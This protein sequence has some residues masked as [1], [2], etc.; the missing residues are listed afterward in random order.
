MADK[1]LQKVAGSP[2][3][4]VDLEQHISKIISQN[5]AIVETLDP[6]WSKKFMSSRNNNSQSN[7]SCSS[8]SISTAHNRH[9][10]TSSLPPSFRPQLYHH[11]LER[12]QQHQQQHQQQQ[13]QHQQ[14]VAVSSPPVPAVSPSAMSRG[15]SPL[16]AV[17]YTRRRYSDV[18]FLNR[19]HGASRLQSALL[20]QPLTSSTAATFTTSTSQAAVSASAVAVS[21]VVSQPS[22][23]IQQQPYHHQQQQQQNN[24]GGHESVIKNGRQ[25]VENMQY[26]SEGPS[27]VNL[28]TSK[29][30]LVK[31]CAPP[32]SVGKPQAC[33][34]GDLHPE[35]PERSVIKDLLL[36]AR[37]KECAA[38][39]GTGK[40][41]SPLPA[42]P[43]QYLAM[44][45]PGNVAGSPVA[46][47][48]GAG[49]AASSRSPLGT[50][51]PPSPPINQE[52]LSMLY[53]VCTI[54]KIAFRNKEN[55]E[56]HQLHYCKGVLASRS[57]LPSQAFSGHLEQRPANL[58]L[59]PH[60]RD[61]PQRVYGAQVPLAVPVNSSFQRKVS[62]MESVLHRRLTEGPPSVSPPAPVAEGQPPAGA[63]GQMGAPIS[64]GTILKKTLESPKKRKFSE[65]VFPSNRFNHTPLFTDEHTAMPSRKISV[66]Q[67][68][69]HSKLNYKYS[70]GSL[71]MSTITTHVAKPVPVFANIA[72]PSRAVSEHE[73]MS[74][75][76][77]ATSAA[78][79]V[80]KEPVKSSPAGQEVKLDILPDYMPHLSLPKTKITL[81]GPLMFPVLKRILAEG[82]D[83]IEFQAKAVCNA[84]EF[85]T[86]KV[87]LLQVATMLTEDTDEPK[88]RE[89]DALQ[90]AVK[91]SS[92]TG[93][94]DKGQ[95][96]SAALTV[97]TTE[98]SIREIPD[99]P[100]RR[101]STLQFQ[102][103]RKMSAFALIGS[104]LV[105]PDTP[106]PKKPS[107][108]HLVTGQSYSFIGL[109]VST[110]TT[111]CCIYRPQPMFVTQETQPKLSMYSNWQTIA[112]QDDLL[113][114]LTPSELLKAYDSDVVTK[115]SM[116]RRPVIYVLSESNN[117]GKGRKLRK[118]NLVTTHS[119]YWISRQQEKAIRERKASFVAR[120]ISSCEFDYDENNMRKISED[121][122]S[123]TSLDSDCDPSHPK[124]V[125]I[126]EGG[127]KSN[128]DYTY[129]RGRGRGKYVCEECGIRCKKPSM[130][131]KHIRTHT[132]LRP[133]S[134]RHCA[135]AFKT[136]GNLTKHMKSKAHHKKCVELGIVP[137]PT[138]IDESQIDSDALAKQEALE[139][140]C[141]GGNLMSDDDDNDEDEEEDEDCSDDEGVPIPL[142][143]ATCYPASGAEKLA[144]ATSSCSSL[145]G[146]HENKLRD[147]TN[148]LNSNGDKLDIGD[149]RSQPR[150]STLQ[151]ENEQ[152]QPRQSVNSM[153]C[154]NSNSSSCSSASQND[155]QEVAQSLLCL[156]GSWSESNN[157]KSETESSKPD[158]DEP[159]AKRK[160]SILEAQLNQG[161]SGWSLSQNYANYAN[162]PRSF[163]FNDV[164]LRA[165][166]A[167]TSRHFRGIPLP[168]TVGS[169]A[170]QP[171]NAVIVSPNN[172]LNT[173]NG[174]INRIVIGE[175]A[176]EAPKC[177]SQDAVVV[178]GNPKPEQMHALYED[179]GESEG[180]SEAD[181]FT[182][183][184]SMSVIQGRPSAQWSAHQ[185]SNQR[186]A[187]EEQPMDLSRRSG[188]GDDD[189]EEA[190][191][192]QDVNIPRQDFIPVGLS[193]PQV[194]LNGKSICHICKTEFSKPHLLH[195]HVNTHYIARPHR[196]DPCQKGFRL[197][198]QLKRH[199]KN[200]EHKNKVNMNSTFGTPTAA[201]PRPF[202]CS[203]CVNTDKNSFR[204]HGHLA[205]HLR[206]KGHIMRLENL[207]KIPFGT[208]AEMERT[209]FNITEI[210]T[211]D[212]ESSLASLKA[213]C[214]RL[215]G[216][217]GVAE[218]DSGAQAWAG[219]SGSEDGDKFE[220]ASM[221][222]GNVDRR[223]SNIMAPTTLASESKVEQNHNDF[224]VPAEP[225]ERAMSYSNDTGRT[226]TTSVYDGLHS[227]PQP[228]PVSIFM[229]SRAVATD[230]SNSFVPSLPSHMAL[231]QQAMATNVTVAQPP[232]APSTQSTFASTRSNTCPMCGQVFKS[233]KFLQVHLYCDHQQ[234]RSTSPYCC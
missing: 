174:G 143:N 192:L 126:F 180:E 209:G 32:T 9:H 225:R 70:L 185:P 30:S 176:K 151:P 194:D 4:A 229:P 45:P 82:T 175:K 124:R 47:L 102:P 29:V 105:S 125:R 38:G 33:T 48:L 71:N 65:P 168:P 57:Y 162:R 50:L 78:L 197:L 23:L 226:R 52:E 157:N 93:G 84:F 37:D 138:C 183:R 24:N 13:R 76:M 177:V 220:Q 103:P 136:K 139:R 206:S 218:Q 222:N 228:S 142:I 152:L 153:N 99:V 43:G 179:V 55:L 56:A 144:T 170:K 188:H 81:N 5:A 211:T 90:S 58:G 49:G 158:S 106:R 198:G 17:N 149:P 95:S 169:L 74:S 97:S 83:N 165:S 118:D 231:P 2:P 167:S 145:L 203:Y 163:S 98:S 201:N 94:D 8:S 181:Y 63:S 67:Q 204:I 27:L 72:S 221:V 46:P 156:S 12:Q 36:K 140:S 114:E 210:E 34:N 159:P 28:L 224:A 134:C 16:E 10:S 54:C 96:V 60:S 141:N 190:M 117:T 137:V 119:S 148:A 109:K 213:I 107:S 31:T 128:E 22:D 182:R 191:Q 79:P 227:E 196:C 116:F 223:S 135:F 11:Q 214:R 122:T 178:K 115:R 35:N 199:E 186:R 73:R 88:G 15:S 147:A 187:N 86:E 69:I 61:G 184:Y 127:F 172:N 62:V 40:R 42:S 64:L 230:N 18:S 87:P 217:D 164:P 173:G 146:Q 133:Y 101:P 195:L 171:S 193:V 189:G 166:L 6:L 131:K 59:T 41:A 202:K 51:S 207:K 216:Q 123:T 66:V 39:G 130:L 121:R 77:A 155:E 200:I 25:I 129:V 110:R 89:E 26:S 233:A 208:F 154:S 205:K 234:Q 14:L 160:V 112:V 21:V 232:P 68:P 132:D 3:S 161:S 53:Y 150:S 113:K 44:S 7:S 108:Q 91:E 80:T 1:G 85:S 120:K 100:A 212:C 215:F 111:F 92:G 219:E 20:G 19:N 104:T 75:T